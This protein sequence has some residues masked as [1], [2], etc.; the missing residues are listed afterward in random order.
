MP[1]KQS[2]AIGVSLL[3]FATGFGAAQDVTNTTDI[4]IL[5]YALTLEHLEY[6]FYNDG[7]E[8]LPENFTNRIVERLEDIRDHEKAH[9]DALTQTI[10]SLGGTPVEPCEYDFGYNSSEQFLS[11]ARV[12]EN[13]GTSAYTGAAYEIENKTLLTVAATIATVEARHSAWLNQV[14]DL[15]PFPAAFDSPL[16]IRSVYGLASHYIVNCSSSLGITHR[17]DLEASSFIVFQGKTVNITSTSLPSNWTSA[18]TWWCV[19]YA[20]SASTSSRVEWDEDAPQT[21]NTTAGYWCRVPE[22]ATMADT[23]LFLSRNQTY[24][25]TDDEP[26][27]AGPT[28]VYVED[29]DKDHEEGEFR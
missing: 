13:V 6:A 4:D 2:L 11:I 27:I 9:V 21:G 16:D 5:N 20:N 14:N 28:I 24:V 22:D 19:F 29:H 3:G 8:L 12:L 18:D 23:Y 26:I 10:T 7:L 15:D 25:L 1:L 17:P